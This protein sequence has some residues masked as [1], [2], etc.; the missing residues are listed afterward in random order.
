MLIVLE[1]LILFICTVLILPFTVKMFIKLSHCCIL[2]CLECHYGSCCCCQW[3]VV[4]VAS[5]ALF[6]V[7]LVRFV[8]GER[9]RKQQLNALHLWSTIHRHTHTQSHIHTAKM[10]IIQFNMH[11]CTCMYAQP[12]ETLLLQSIVVFAGGKL[13]WHSSAILGYIQYTALSQRA[14]NEA[15]ELSTNQTLDLQASDSAYQR[16]CTFCTSE[17]TSAYQQARASQLITLLWPTK[18]I[19][20]QLCSGHCSPV[21]ATTA[22]IAPWPA[23]ATL[24]ITSKQVCCFNPACSSMYFA[25]YTQHCIAHKCC[26]GHA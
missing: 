26:Q 23:S 13:Q 22:L 11:I 21:C 1:I 18:S 19:G 12:Q 7:I 14:V 24:P 10:T 15:T 6:H 20:E 5:A 2:R 16:A 25:A 3:H 9:K 8:C 17:A 4:A